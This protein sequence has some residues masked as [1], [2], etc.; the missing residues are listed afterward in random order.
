EEIEETI[1]LS[2]E[3]PLDWA[4]YTITIALPGTDIHSDLLESGQWEGQY[5]R[6]YS[7]QRFSGPPGYASRTLQA[8]ELEVLLRRAYRRF[9]LRPVFM[10]GK[11]VNRRLWRQLPCTLATAA[12]L[13]QRRRRKPERGLG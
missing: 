5:W 7:L 6:D 12:G 13:R 3:L 10:V 9:Y 8:E 11:A 4:S 2:C 1:R